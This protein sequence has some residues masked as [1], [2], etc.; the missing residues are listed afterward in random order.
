VAVRGRFSTYAVQF[1]GIRVDGRRALHC[2]FFP[3]HDDIDHDRKSY[4][5]VLDGGADY[6]RINYDI[7]EG[8][9]FDFDVNGE[10]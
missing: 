6:W 2:N 9:C 4:V 8:R 5:Y 10:S 3:A 7:E 1:V